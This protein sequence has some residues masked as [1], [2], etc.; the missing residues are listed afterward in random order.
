MQMEE[1][2]ACA[3]ERTSRFSAERFIALSQARI[4]R[5]LIW[6]SRVQAWS[7]L[8]AR[9]RYVVER[10]TS[11]EE[12]MFSARFFVLQSSGAEQTYYRLSRTKHYM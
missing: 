9:H 4:C 3:L 2:A 11:H 7:G 1:G 10:G 12:C 5:H 6:F 8:F